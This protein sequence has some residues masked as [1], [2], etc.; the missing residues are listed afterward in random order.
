MISEFDNLTTSEEIA[1]NSSLITHLKNNL[2]VKTEEELRMALVSRLGRKS[3]GKLPTEAA[4]K[5]DESQGLELDLA[6]NQKENQMI[7]EKNQKLSQE[8][9]LAK[10]HKH[11][12]I[13]YY[14]KI[15]LVLESH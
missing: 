6:N 14:N 1:T 12:F 13:N 5:C 7:L 15:A 8:L 9:D 10:V 11:S 2:N 4:C 3:F